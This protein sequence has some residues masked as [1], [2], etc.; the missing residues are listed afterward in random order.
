[1]RGTTLLPTVF[2]AAFLPSCSGEDV[3]AADR[4]RPDVLLLL[5]DTLRAD[6]LGCYDYPRDTSPT[7]DALA[8]GG[9]LCTRAS[10]QAPWTIPSVSSLMTGRYLTSHQERPAPDATTLAEVYQEAGYDTLGVVANN[11][12][13]PEVGFERGFDTFVTRHYRDEKG[14][15]RRHKDGAFHFVREWAQP[16]LEAHAAQEERPPLFFYLHVVDPHDVYQPHPHLAEVLPHDSVPTVEPAGWW[17]D[18]I[19]DIGMAAPEDDPGWEG[20]LTRMQRSRGNYDREIRYTDDQLSETLADLEALGIGEN[21]LVAVI[22]DHGEELW[23][24][25]TPLP[26]EQQRKTNPERLFF[27]THG[28]VMTEPSLRTPFLLSGAGVPEGVVIDAPVENIDLFPT[29]LE[30]CDLGVDFETH[31]KSLVPLFG[32]ADLDRDASFAYVQHA[33]AV[34]EES[35]GLKLVL[36]TEHGLKLGGVPTLHD[37]RADPHE[38]TDLFES[39]PDDV[40][41]LTERAMRFL[42]EYPS[43]EQVIEGEAAAQLLEA[44]ESFGYA[45]DMIRGGQEEAATALPAP[46]GK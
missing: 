18:T 34:R 12:I 4:P 23:E 37:L 26:A 8:E 33:M 28:Y 1:M 32:G 44:L 13:L 45:G 30:L 38:R 3:L 39:R 24:H 46:D 15:R 43:S 2:L 31:G 27:Q 14:R 11:V 29:L 17:E 5:I 42:G 35:T 41:R 19:A 21:L 36:P 10:S 6:H 16:H 7:L 25:L 22:S 40:A 20:E 9:V